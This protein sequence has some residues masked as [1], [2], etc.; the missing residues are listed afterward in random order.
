MSGGLG[1]GAGAVEPLAP[2]R[3]AERLVERMVAAI[4][5]GSFAVGQ[6]LPPERELAAQ[7]GVSRVTLR[8]A[9]HQLERQGY[10]AIRRGRAGG[11]FVTSARGS[12]SADLVRRALEPRWQQLEWT[13]D[14][15]DHLNPVIARLAAERRTPED[16]D[17]IHAAVAAYVAAEDDRTAMRMA[18]HAIHN[19]I[20][21]ATH[22]PHLVVIEHQM[23]SELSLGT[24]A[25]PTSA[26]I[27][28]QALRDHRELAAAVAAGEAD[29]AADI[30]QRHIHE[31]VERPLRELYNRAAEFPDKR[32]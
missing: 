15:N 31:L 29:L 17:R 14:L 32:G 28:A 26:E 23:R 19:A 13:F 30:A 10:V 8:E 24:D 25:L 3:N 21:Q 1:A 7:L 12:D 18:D 2:M 16:V 11:A 4:A 22:N 6:K 9:L 5:L 27:R 20:A